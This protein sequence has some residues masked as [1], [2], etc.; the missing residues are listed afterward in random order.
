MLLQVLPNLVGGGAE[1]VAINLA[2][3]WVSFG[4]TAQFVLME[5]R[6]EFLDAVDPSIQ[7]DSLDCSRLRQVPLPLTRYLRQCQPTVTLVHMWPLTSEAVLAWWL[8]GRPGKIVVCEHIGL[9]DHV[10]RD[11]SI[12]LSVACASLRLSHPHAS[13]V[14]AVSNG[15][16]LDL[17]HLSGM[18]KQSIEVIYNPVVADK[19]PVLTDSFKSQMRRK[20]W[21]GDFCAHLLTVGSLKPQKNHRLLLEAFAEF[22]EKFNAALVILGEGGLRDELEQDVQE[23]NLQGRVVMPGFHSDPS[24]WYQSADLFVLSSD[25]EGLPTVLIE[26]L[27]C[28][29]PV[30]ST[31]CPHGPAEILDRGR[32]GRLV[33]VGDSAAL[34]SAMK[35]SL[36]EA[37]DHSALRRRAQAFAI[38]SIASQYLEYFRSKKAHL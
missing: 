37:H 31:D 5:R 16:A 10:K 30:V 12:P 20:L 27:A 34:V 1:R 28:G 38:P 11:L 15:A 25:F 2:H 8:A 26:A 23:L 36:L 32:Y 18:S 4:H 17:A 6:G 14:I 22:A 35:A 29:T 33:P 7:V 3:A 21:G 19:M 9:S 24:C 13:G